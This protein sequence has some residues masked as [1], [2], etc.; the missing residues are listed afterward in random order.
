MKQNII[1]LV[2]SLIVLT[3]IFDVF[4]V[5]LYILELI[6]SLVAGWFL[7]GI[8]FHLFNFYIKEYASS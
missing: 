5:D 2:V 8:I 7:L 6:L 3:I 1:G 4:K